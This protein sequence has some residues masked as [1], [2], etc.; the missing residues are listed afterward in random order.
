[1]IADAPPGP[2]RRVA[3]LG[4]PAVAVPPLRA[5]VAAGFEVPVVVTAPDKRRGRGSA[6]VPTPV[7]AVAH[8]LGLAVA[9]DA[10]ALLDHDLDAG[11]VVAFGQILRPPV[12][13]HVPLVNLHFSLLPRWRG[14]APVE[15]A[16][17]AGDAETGVCVMAV[18][19]GLDTGDV[20]ASD[21]TPVGD[22]TLA[23]LWDELAVRGSELLV[24]ALGAGL[25]GPVPQRGEVTY[26]AKLEKADRFL[27]PTAEGAEQLAR[28]VRLGGAW[29][30]F[31]GA[32]L[33]VVAARPVELDGPSVADG[34]APGA[35]LDGPV[36]VAAD[37]RGLLL[38]VVRPEGRGDVAAADWVRGIR[39][40]PDERVG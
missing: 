21:R 10:T 30:A 31:R 5:L 16:I 1:M 20:Y 35:L 9:H 22:K 3:Y 37:G 27:D 24:E 25:A 2:I 28:R 18:E 32:R 39:P 8:E 23:E 34:A 29:T 40:A 14:A 6:A 36:V 4:T 13:G 17:L 7:A 15:R 38:E 11:V 33:G 26:A 19:E 12:L